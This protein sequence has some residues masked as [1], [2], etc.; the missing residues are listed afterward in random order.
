MIVALMIVC[1]LCFGFAGSTLMIRNWGEKFDEIRVEDLYFHLPFSV[2]GP[3]C[4]L[5]AIG[6]MLPSLVNS[7][8]ILWSKK[9]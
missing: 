6:E 2:L 4:F 9:K 3:I 7:R 8:K 1:W 5:A